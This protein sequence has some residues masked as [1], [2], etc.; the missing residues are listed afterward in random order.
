MAE[1]Q[2]SFS[3]I[4]RPSQAS[5]SARFRAYLVIDNWDDWFRYSTLYSLIVFGEDAKRYD[6][7][8]VK[9]GQL[10]MRADQKRPELEDRFIQLNENYFSLGQSA[11]T[12]SRSDVLRRI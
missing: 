9:I 2:F 3:V 7:G 10:K 5:S 12:T 1:T 4:N 6:I 11:T 8:A